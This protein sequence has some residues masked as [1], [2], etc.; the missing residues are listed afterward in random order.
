MTLCRTSSPNISTWKT[1]NINPTNS[2]NT[3]RWLRWSWRRSSCRKRASMA[4]KTFSSGRWMMEMSLTSSFLNFPSSICCPNGRE[5]KI[6]QLVCERN[7]SRLIESLLKRLNSDQ[8]DVLAHQSDNYGN[9]AKDALNDDKKIIYANCFW[10]TNVFCYH[11]VREGPLIWL[12]KNQKK[13]YENT[14]F[15]EKKAELFCDPFYGRPHYVN[16]GS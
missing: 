16:E 12:I 13:F 1:Y 5:L 8:L 6:L 10:A 14:L 9:V 2:C 15:G 3:W 7:E 11:L 4:P